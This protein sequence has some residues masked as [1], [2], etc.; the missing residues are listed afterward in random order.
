MKTR[1]RPK[2]R[3]CRRC[4]CTENCITENCQEKSKGAGCFWIEEDLCSA[5]LTPAERKRFR[6]GRGES[7]PSIPT[8]QE[9]LA[10]LR[11]QIKT[12]RRS[13]TGTNGYLTDPEIA[14]EIESL[15]V[16]FAVVQIKLSDRWMERLA[17]D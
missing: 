3:A 11:E 1:R 12:L 7:R 15:Q 8:K 13:Y 9:I 10:A 2:E 17:H 14:Q 16:A 4:G 6:N 5:C